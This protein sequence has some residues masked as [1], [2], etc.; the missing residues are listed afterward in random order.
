MLPQVRVG[1]EAILSADAE[2]EPVGAAESGT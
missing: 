2:E 1:I